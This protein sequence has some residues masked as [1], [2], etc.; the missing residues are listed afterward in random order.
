MTDRGA[1]TVVVVLAHIVLILGGAV[2][3][4]LHHPVG[5]VCIVFGGGISVR[6]G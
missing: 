2:L 4:A 3:V 5:W 6:M 1:V